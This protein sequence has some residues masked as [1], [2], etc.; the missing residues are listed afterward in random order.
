[1]TPSGIEPATFR[2][3]AQH[4]NHC[5]S[6]RGPH[7]CLKAKLIS[8]VWKQN[9]QKNTSLYVSTKTKG[10]AHDM[11]NLILCGLC[12]P[13]STV[14]MGYFNSCNGTQNEWMKEGRKEAW[15]KL[16]TEVWWGN[17]IEKVYENY[18]RWWWGG[19]ILNDLW[20]ISSE[21]IQGWMKL[22]LNFIPWLVECCGSDTT[23]VLP[24][25]PWY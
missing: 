16:H 12:S 4:L 19:N 8:N 11:T 17:T 22:G 18:D 21:D 23:L 20:Q 2:C 3:A 9:A 1:M 14:T 13:P 10:I 15:S 7:I 5:A 6:Y 25:R 24:Q